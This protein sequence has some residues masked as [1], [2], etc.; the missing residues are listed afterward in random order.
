MACRT[1]AQGMPFDPNS[2]IE[3]RALSLSKGSGRGCAVQCIKILHWL[4]SSLL[5]RGEVKWNRSILGPL[6]ER[7]TEHYVNKGE[8]DSDFG[9]DLIRGSGRIKTSV[10]LSD[11]EKVGSKKGLRKGGISARRGR[12]E[13]LFIILIIKRT[14]G[15]RKSK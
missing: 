3:L 5:G 4:S 10:N 2:S 13:N 1:K 11:E 8:R 9:L 12:N 6:G 15:A 7:L 14:K